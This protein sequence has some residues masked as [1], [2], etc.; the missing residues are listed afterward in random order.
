MNSGS[1]IQHMYTRQI[2]EF[3]LPVPSLNEQQE[4]VSEVEAQLS[5]AEYLSIQV[6]GE[7]A[8]AAALRQAILAAA[9]RGEL[10]AQ[11][12]TDEPA[13]VLLERIRAER[14]TAGQTKRG[15]ARRVAAGA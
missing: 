11:D 8:R 4:I 10:V 3:T 12:P 1:L 2:D 14:A 9:F 6:K 13:A 15:R 5:A 7:E